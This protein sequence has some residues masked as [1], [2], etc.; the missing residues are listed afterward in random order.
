[1]TGDA[2]RY[3]IA[4]LLGRGGMAEVFEAWVVGAQGFER[5]V[6]LKRVLADASGDEG[7]LA[8]FTDE[9]QIVSQLHHA[10]IVGVFDFGLMD[11]L[12]FLVFEL[13]EGLDVEQLGERLREEGEQLPVALALHV[14]TEIAHALDYAH[15]ARDAQGRAMNIVHRDVSPENLLLSWQ[16]DVKLGD[17][18]IAFAKRRIEATQLGVA[19]GKRSYMA[20]EQRAGRRV[21]G[22]ADVFALGCVLHEMLTGR[23][24]V[25]DGGEVALDA[26]L[27]E[28]VR[29]IV[30]RATER[31]PSARYAS[32]AELAAAAGRAMMRR[33]DEDARTSLRSLMQ[34]F[35]PSV[36]RAPR[37]GAELVDLELV[38]DVDASGPLRR[39]ESRAEAAP[40]TPTVPLGVEEEDDVETELV[41]VKTAE[42]AV[43]R[44]HLIGDVVGSH[45]ITA[46]L[47]AGHSA[48]V[49]R[50]RHVV[51]DREVALKVLHPHHARRPHVVERLQRE[52]KALSRLSHPNIVGVLDA[53]V[54]PEGLAWIAMELVDGRTLSE[55]VREEAPLAPERVLRFARQLASGLQAAHAAGLVHRDLKP[56]NIAVVGRGA[57]ETLRIL[58]FG[59]VR[60]IHA[61]APKTKLTH[62]DH[63]LGTPQYIA[64]EQILGASTVGPEADLYSLGV[65]LFE[66]LAGRRP[67]AGRG[68]AVMERHL[69]ELPPALPPTGGLEHVVDR[70][71]AKDPRD[72]TP[73]ADA[74]LAALDALPLARGGDE[75]A[76]KT[77]VLPHL[78]PPAQL[79]APQLVVA[80]SASIPTRW[81]FAVMLV[82]V[83][84]VSVLAVLR[85]DRDRALARLESKIDAQRTTPAQP[86]VA[87]PDVVPRAAAR[88]ERTLDVA[89]DP[90]RDDAADD[91]PREVARDPARV[92]G[93]PSARE[94]PIARRTPTD[95]SIAESAP[96]TTEPGPGTTPPIDLADLKARLARVSDTLA[97][98]ST[99]L[100]A[101][102]LDTFERRYFALREALRGEPSE[103]A[104]TAVARDLTTLE[105]DVAAR[106]TP[107]E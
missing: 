64:P 10:N 14:T 93:A 62:A 17:F 20:P 16:G 24:A 38:L 70:L 83:A 75:G 52:A 58:D 2:S 56:G 54:T 59:L 40:V 98:R 65:I 11:G 99:T 91:P 35:E 13:V 43:I 100:P 1:M 50:A 69:A 34:R 74:V 79:T 88:E 68:V 95:R 103:S 29:A 84:G 41:R 60:A 55:L 46:L 47:G 53:G 36:E 9:A 45:K 67:F 18:G 85:V 32:A 89:I 5:K 25:D 19:K 44:E 30:A 86:E 37:A 7:F 6:A 81:I 76:T 57:Q 33:L 104:L 77:P 82:L 8:S 71:L 28:D 96:S 80:P 78:A 90:R 97:D 73:S 51:L 66:L 61:G 42:R 21:D 39:F 31:E 107:S 15:R 49:Y 72:R 92:D 102:E 106:L 3:R 87:A 94:R 12:P 63:P 27:D 101:A 22:R 23:S 4:R 48:R 26:A 105:R